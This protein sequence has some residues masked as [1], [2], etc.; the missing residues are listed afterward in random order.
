MQLSD[1]QFRED[2]FDYLIENGFTGNT[3]FYLSEIIRKGMYR[4]EKKQVFK[5][6]LSEDFIEWAKNIMYLPSIGNRTKTDNPYAT[7]KEK[8]DSII[9]SN[10]ILSGLVKDTFSYSIVQKDGK[11][12]EFPLYFN[13]MVFDIFVQEMKT[14]Y[15]E[16][17]LKYNGDPYS[18]ANK[19]GAGG[20]LLERYGRYGL[21][22]PKMAS[23]A[24]SSR[25]CYLALRNGTD[26]L[27]DGKYISGHDVEF[28]K[29]CKIFHDSPTAPQLDAFIKNAEV[30]IYIEA[31]CHEIFDSHKVVLKNKY[32]EYFENDEVLHSFLNNVQKGTDNFELP[33][34]LFGIDK[35]SSR[36]NIK[37]LICHLIGIKEQTKDR[38]AELVYLFFEPISNNYE[39][40]AFLYK[41]FNDLSS[42]IKA[43]FES[44][45]IKNFCEQNR[46]KLTAIKET[47]RTMEPLNMLNKA[48][49][50]P[51]ME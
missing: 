27:T 17:F 25:F 15:P 38:T 37:Q 35:T 43:I 29:E 12:R 44:D 49:I 14:C 45:V 19:G 13:K 26:A 30:D 20:E 6:K 36:F 33:L 21:T 32:L 51:C 23:V 50:Y 3:A 47:S 8:F 40:S 39:E 28:E 22:P 41:I 34:S 9:K 4:H 11:I 16:H 24:S 10:L 48:V 42:E 18:K 7:K 5:D 46:I 31:K 1:I 2:C